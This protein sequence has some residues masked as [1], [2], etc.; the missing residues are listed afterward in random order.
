MREFP[1]E[2]VERI[3]WRDTIS[4][5]GLPKQRVRLMRIG[6][7]HPIDLNKDE[8][9]QLS[10]KHCT[11]EVCDNFANCGCLSSTWRPRD[12][13]AGPSA[14]S[15]GGTE[16]GIDGIEFNVSTGKRGRYAR[17]VK[18]VAGLSIRRRCKM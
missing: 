12:V 7:F 4:L 16:A 15:D 18:K 9:V 17:H 8:I 6:D 10:C 3:S 5:Q 13:N 11:I 2:K 1:F 14:I